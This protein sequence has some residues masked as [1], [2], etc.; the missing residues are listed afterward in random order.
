MTLVTLKDVDIVQAGVDYE[1]STGTF[2]F[3]M[4]DLADAV[5][6]AAEDP[7]VKNPRLKLGHTSKLNQLIQAMDDGQPALGTVQNMH[8]NAL[9]NKIIGDLVGVPKWFADIMASAYPSRSFEGGFNYKTNGTDRTYRMVIKAVSFLGVTWPGCATIDDIQAL[10]GDEMPEGVELLA[11]SEKGGGQDLS[12]SIAAS[13]NVDD[14]RRQ[15]YDGPGQ[16]NNDFL[17]V[18]AIYI[19]PYEIIVMNEDENQL[20]R[21][22]Y[23]CSPDGEVTFGEPQPVIVQYVPDPLAAGSRM[24]VVQCS[25][26]QVVAFASRSESRPDKQD[27]KG[28][29][30]MDPA[31]I[32]SSLGL[33]AEATDEEV[34]AKIAELQGHTASQDAGSGDAGSSTSTATPAEQAQTAPGGGTT[35]AGT[36]AEQAPAGGSP[37][38]A[39]APEGSGSGATSEQAQAGDKMVTVPAEVWAQV[40]A[41]AQRGNQVYTEAQAKLKSES[42]EQ[43]CEKGRIAASQR[44]QF[45]LLWDKDPEGTHKLLTASVEQGGLADNLVPV[46]ARGVNSGEEDIAASDSY[47][48]SWLSDGERAR[49]AAAAGRS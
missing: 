47:D 19:D 7:A 1:I 4:E 42:I 36:G 20:E 48:P 22:S 25:G 44:E 27:P 38:T 28:G 34:K 37:G 24:A 2:S 18:Q 33:P 41:G 15:F 26:R 45:G 3:T 21:Y 39:A 23:E 12:F 13:V 10:Y 46:T 49:L 5:K 11:A 31:E 17:W 9:G 6:A 14:V 35:E 32:R 40:Q 30:Q 16:E 29:Q 43:G 8:L